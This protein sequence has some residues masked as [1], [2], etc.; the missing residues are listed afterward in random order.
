MTQQITI[1]CSPEQAQAIAEALECY[2]RICMGQLEHIEEMARLGTVKKS[3]HDPSSEN[4]KLS[5]EECEDFRLLLAHAKK[6]YF[7]F[8]RFGGSSHGLG[9][10]RLS[11][12]A[13]RAYCA[14][15]QIEQ[16]LAVMRNPNPQ[17]R[18]V[19]YDGCSV[20]YVD[21]PLVKVDVDAVSVKPIKNEQDYQAVMQRI[22]KLM[23]QH[24][25]EYCAELDVLA[26]L[27]VAYETEHHSFRSK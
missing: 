2:I 5:H 18:S 7:G 26:S 13:H 11:I 6:R 17:F 4:G 12:N 16:V 19:D 20:S 25:G 9:S 24:S 8:D 27:V 1:T 23:D 3:I 10:Q 22:S 15:K 21:E 14:K